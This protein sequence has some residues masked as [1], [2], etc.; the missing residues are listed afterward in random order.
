MIAAQRATAAPGWT[1]IDGVDV[2]RGLAIWFVLMN[3]VNM[4]LFIAKIPYAEGLPDQLTSSLVWNGQYGVQMFFAVSGFLITS[5]SIRR[6]GSLASVNVREFY[7]LRFARIAPLLFLLLAVLCAFH[8]AG[9]KDFVVSAD[10]GGL[11][12]ALIAALTFQVNLLEAQR[13]Y[14]PGNW[15]IL[16]SLSVEE[17][18][19]LFFPALCWLL[20]RGRPLVVLLLGFVILGPI[21]R[22]AFAHGNE[23]W[24]ETSYL[25]SMDAI[26]LGCLTA[27]GLSRVRLTRSVLRAAGGLGAAMLMFILGFSNQVDA[28]GLGHSGLDM[29]ILAIG[30]CLIIAAA[31]QSGWKSP[32]VIFPLLNLG[33]RSYEVYLT[34][35]FIVFAMFALFRTA[36]SPL[37]AVP[38]LFVT[39]ILLSGLIGEWVARYYSEPMNRLL[40]SHWR[41]GLGRLGSVVG[42]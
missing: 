9:L 18:F 23:I 42:H 26:A 38:I 1:R 10:T 35:M 14:L 32:R 40:R 25:G 2:L 12:R 30:T 34:H 15:D 22:T 29:T 16:W 31:A 37:P 33:Q 20:G 17:M 8:A 41:H 19:Y 11:G 6:W 7:A 24:Q 21:G 28:W 39:V 5:T 27:M 3:H 4:R 36:G 13:G